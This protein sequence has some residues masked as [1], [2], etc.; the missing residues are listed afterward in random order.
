MMYFNTPLLGSLGT[1]SDYVPA[2]MN[3]TLRNT[4]PGELVQAKSDAVATI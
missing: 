4:F 1:I 3:S 2:K